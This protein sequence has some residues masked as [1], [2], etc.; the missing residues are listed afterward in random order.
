[1]IEVRPIR[2]QGRA[3]W[4]AEWRDPVTGRICSKSTKATKKKE[5]DAFCARLE[6]DLKD[7]LVA[8]GPEISWDEFRKRHE[9]EVQPALAKK[10]RDKY[11]AVFNHVEKRIKPGRLAALNAGQISRLMRL[12]R[13]AGDAEITIRTSIV[14][15]RAALRWAHDVGMISHS[16]KVKL[17]K[18][19]ATPKGRAIT[20]EE[21]ERLV[22]AV[23]AIVGASPRFKKDEKRRDARI[24]AWERLITG[25][26]WSGLRL[27]EALDLHWTSDRRMRVDFSGKRPMFVMRP[28]ADKTFRDRLFPMAPEFAAFLA[29]TPARERRGFVFDPIPEI[30]YGSRMRLDSVSKVIEKI[31]RK[32][33]VKVSVDGRREKFASAHD[34]RRAFGFR[35]AMRVTPAVLKE[36]MRH[37]NVATTMQFYVG[38]E[39]EAIADVLWSLTD[40]STDT[41]A[42]SPAPSD[43]APA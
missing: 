26:W 16:P 3:Y 2:R 24:A 4:Q 17:P 32:A 21:F 7:G 20:R 22:K 9:D 28:Q 30:D 23:P 37:E 38:H 15:L 39:A 27:G 31:G 8:H 12:M 13:D 33:K 34:L 41:K 19:T 36:L 29:K 6:R 25:L 43:A 42:V 1:M 14:Y 11:R 18:R 40:T 35:W 10:T 5:A